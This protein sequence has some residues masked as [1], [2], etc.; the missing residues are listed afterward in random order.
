MSLYAPGKPNQ[1]G[2]ATIEFVQS[3]WQSAVASASTI[4]VIGAAP[5]APDT[6]IWG[7]LSRADGEL[8]YVGNR[9]LF[10][11]WCDENRSGRGRWLAH[12]F[13]EGLNDV[14]GGLCGH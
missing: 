5:H 6:H 10:E 1:M 14:I 11:A 13:E 7:P 3:A 12:T 4:V 8:L 2:R 9:T